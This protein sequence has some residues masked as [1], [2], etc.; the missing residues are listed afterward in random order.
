MFQ[1][2]GVMW[3]CPHCDQMT[4][5]ATKNAAQIILG[6]SHHK[7]AFASH[8]SSRLISGRNVDWTAEKSSGGNQA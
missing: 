2:V 7:H 4:F 5:L 6:N 1:A 8:M 3:A